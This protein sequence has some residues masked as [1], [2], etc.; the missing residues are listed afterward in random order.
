MISIQLIEYENKINRNY[1]A[2]DGPVGTSLNHI[3]KN[4]FTIEHGQGRL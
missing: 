3:L 1:K 2:N 4:Y